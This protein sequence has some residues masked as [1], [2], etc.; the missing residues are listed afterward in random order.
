LA[1]E[2]TD[3]T[4]FVGDSWELFSWRMMANYVSPWE[5]SRLKAE[6]KD[7]SHWCA[8]WSAVAAG[9]TSRGDEAAASGHGNTAAAAYIAAGLFYHW[10]SFLFTHDSEQFRAALTGGE[11]AF[12]KAAP[13][14]HDPM[15]ILNVPFEGTEL[16]GYLRRPHGASGPVPLA[17]LIPGA[18]SNKEELYDLGTH[19][20]RR[21]IAV[22]AFDGP[23]HGLVSFDLKLR[24]DYEKPI[25]A[26]LDAL[27]ARP[28][29]DASR[30]ALCGI[31]Y[32]GQFAI[33]GA[34]FD[35][36]VKAAVSISSWYS[37]AGRFPNQRPVSR[38]ALLQYLGPD[39]LAVQN[40]MTLEGICEKVTVP[41][42]QVYGGRDA[43]SPIEQAQQIAAEVRGPHTLKFY[44][45]GVHVCNNLWYEA[46]PFVADWLADTLSATR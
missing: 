27:L 26:V 20:L 8:G 35:Q 44:E 16:R 14:A 13:H 31:S 38:R 43:A 11:E 17:V 46:R 24:P 5:L 42:L 22:Y 29:L 25:S 1:V 40:T 28:D 6:I 32:G 19:I 4:S 9:H 34:A 41:L 23:G 3:T 36:R 21:G 37:A 15:L 2:T 7:W 45:D 33:R 12:R 18:D 10:G 30:V 39:P